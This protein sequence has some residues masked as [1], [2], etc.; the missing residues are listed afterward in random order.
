M[1]KKTGR[2]PLPK[3]TAKKE[4]FTVKLTGEDLKTIAQDIKDS[5]RGKPEW[6][7]ERLL[8]GLQRQN[9]RSERWRAKELD[10]KTVKFKMME[11]PNYC[12]IGGGKFDA[13][14]RGDGSMDVRITTRNKFEQNP[15]AYNAVPVTQR[16]I[17]LLEQAPAGSGFDFF[18]ID[19]L[20]P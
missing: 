11:T 7:R 5:G 9:V 8:W 3:G 12:I 13:I 17:D 19:P 14:Q 6:A 15:L 18:L 2:P 16:G 20:A 10:G 4:V 1:N